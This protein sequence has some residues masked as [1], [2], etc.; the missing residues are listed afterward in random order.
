MMLA[1]ARPELLDAHPTWGSG[2]LAQT[3][4]PLEPLSP[5]DAGHLAAH[6][7]S[8]AGDGARPSSAWWRSPRA[9]RSSSRN[10]PLR[11]RSPANYRSR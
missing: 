3:T 8:A 2:L 1:L 7:L 9:T 5:E 6:L 11:Q 10:S 4:I